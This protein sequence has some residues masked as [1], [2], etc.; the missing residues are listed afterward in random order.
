MLKYK[1]C[2]KDLIR[3]LIRKNKLTNIDDIESI[4]KKY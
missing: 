1:V 4:L 3:T 2:D